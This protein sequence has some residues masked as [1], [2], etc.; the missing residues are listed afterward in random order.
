MRYYGGKGKLVD[1]IFETSRQFAGE[2]YSF[3]DAF[4]GTGVVGLEARKR[5]HYVEANDIL[6]FSQCL[7]TSNLCF[8]SSHGFE[9]LGGLEF[10]IEHLNSLHPLQG[11]ITEH[12]SPH[13]S[14]GR[15]YF[16][17]A[18]AM[19]IDAIR[20]QIELWFDAGQVN[21]TEKQALIGL[22]MRA[23][24]RVSN[25][26]GT[27][28]AYLKNWDSRAHKDLR[29]DPQEL[30]TY[31]PIGVSYNLDV[32]AFLKQSEVDVVYLDPPYNSR[33]YSSNYF[34]LELIA[35]GNLSKD[36]APRGVTGSISY[37]EKKSL[38]SSKRAVRAAFETMFE[39]I[40]APIALLSYNNEG[41]IPIPELVSLM[42]DFGPVEAVK[43]SHKRFR[44]INQDGSNVKTDEHLLVLRK[45]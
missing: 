35:D 26:T 31:G 17:R 24:N 15:Q 13:G 20:T 29:L 41:L 38:F 16:S 34:L 10:A 6:Y 33:D 42:A 4:S 14:A 39:S 5:S 40:Q 2:S 37:P 44:S 1:F 45:A 8:T 28:G 21:P 11:S 9:K 30:N 43:K 19:K 7:A 3:A 18:N 27:Y 23:I 12:Y 32:N 36:L 25:V 22:L